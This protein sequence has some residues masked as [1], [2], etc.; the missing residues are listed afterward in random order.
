MH[1]ENK[2]GAHRKYIFRMKIKDFCNQCDEISI[3]GL[4]DVAYIDASHQYEDVFWEL[5]NIQKYLKSNSLILLNDV[6]W[7]KHAFEQKMGV[8]RAVSAAIQITNYRP[9]MITDSLFAD[10][11]LT[12]APLEENSL[13]MEFLQNLENAPN[14]MTEVPDEALFAF[15]HNVPK[16]WKKRMLPSFK[17]HS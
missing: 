3:S 16:F 12:N 5:I 7:G 1:V 13:A 14:K 8:L 6:H 9:I 15:N 4:F 11:V 2:F 10:L 17:I